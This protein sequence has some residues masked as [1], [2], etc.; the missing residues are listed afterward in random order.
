MGGGGIMCAKADI[1]WA[2]FY[3]TAFKILSGYVFSRAV[4]MGG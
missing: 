2:N 3:P 1:F 4:Q